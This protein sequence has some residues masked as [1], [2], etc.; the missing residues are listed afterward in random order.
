[1]SFKLL[2]IVAFDIVIIV[3]VIAIVVKV[4]DAIVSS[5]ILPIPP[6]VVF[7]VV[8]DVVAH[9]IV[10]CFRNFKM[11]MLFD[12]RAVHWHAHFSFSLSNMP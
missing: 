1:M 11:G 7:I 9:A 4:E 8:A 6:I 10:A 12:G 5:L 3:M 2:L